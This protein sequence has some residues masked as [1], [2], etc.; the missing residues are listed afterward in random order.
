MQQ[1]TA[2]LTTTSRRH[3]NASH[4]V[5]Q[6]VNK[7]SVHLVQPA[8]KQAL[9]DHCSKFVY[10]QHFLQRVAKQYIQHSATLTNKVAEKQMQA[11][12]T[13]AAV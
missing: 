10:L 8:K 7:R 4:Y 13:T 12:L 11:I 9:A 5:H 1:S 3:G 2:A 6:Q